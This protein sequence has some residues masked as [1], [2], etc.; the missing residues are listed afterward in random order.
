M[1]GHVLAH[2]VGHHVLQHERRLRGRRG[3]RTRDHEARA[4]AVAARLRLLLD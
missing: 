3:A 1:L 2:E 4:E